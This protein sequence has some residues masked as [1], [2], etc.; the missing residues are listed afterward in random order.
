VASGSAPEQGSIDREQAKLSCSSMRRPSSAEFLWLAARQ[1]N[2][3]YSIPFQESEVLFVKAHCECRPCVG[4]S[5]IR[6]GSAESC[7]LRSAC[8]DS[9]LFAAAD[10]RLV[11]SLC[12]TRPDLKTVSR[13]APAVS[14][15]GMLR[16][17]ADEAAVKALGSGAPV[18][19]PS[20]KRCPWGVRL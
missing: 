1:G 20:G 11:D 18:R 7:Q 5:A 8:Q 3:K 6:S 10:M 13:S 19:M 9:R 16:S 15:R 17:S 2:L 4:P 14:A 12:S